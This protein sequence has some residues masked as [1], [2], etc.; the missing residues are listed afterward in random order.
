M[1]EIFSYQNLQ[2]TIIRSPRRKTIAIQIK[3]GQA[4]M[5]VPKSL[6]KAEIARLAIKKNRWI[7][8]KLKIQSQINAIEP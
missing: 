5:L 8:E 2:I 3:A 4:F 7:Q 1:T 6:P